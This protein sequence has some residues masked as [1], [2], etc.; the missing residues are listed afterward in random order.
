[1]CFLFRKRAQQVLAAHDA[2]DAALAEH[3]DSLDPVGF[4]QARD[5]RRI[6]VLAD[7]DDRARHDVPRDTL[8]GT[9]GGQ[10][11]GAEGSIFRQQRQPPV[12][13]LVAF[14]V[15][16]ADEIALAYHPDERARLVQHRNRADMVLEQEPGNVPDRHIGANR[17]YL[18]RH[19]G[20][21]CRRWPPWCMGLGGQLAAAAV[22]IPR[23]RATYLAYHSRVLAPLS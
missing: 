13:S 22:R 7:G 8:R 16:A 2:D 14:R 3:G 9:Q 5:P 15:V 17:D 6:R 1:M 12:P 19:P 21:G 11:F 10:E 23:S 4:E 18:A 20:A